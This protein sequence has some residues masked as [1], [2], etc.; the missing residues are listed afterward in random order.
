M[1]SIDALTG[2]LVLN[3]CTIGYWLYILTK[4]M[5]KRRYA[6]VQLYSIMRCH[7]IPR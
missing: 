4:H 5:G 2:L 7:R 6:D 3:E 1:T